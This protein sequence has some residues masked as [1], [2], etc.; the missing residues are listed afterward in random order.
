MNTARQE[1]DIC[2]WWHAY[3]FDNPLRRLLH[4]PRRLFA[5]YLS[6]GMTAV[7][8]GCGMGYFSIGMSKIVGDGGKILAVDVQP[9]M[10]SVLRRRASRAGVNHIIDTCLIAGTGLD[11][12]IAVDFALVFWAMHEIPD[13]NGLAHEITNGLKP[14]G[15]C[16]VVEPAF[17]VRAGAFA[18]QV[19]AFTTSGLRE[20]A[21]PKVALSRA[22]VFKKA[23]SRGQGAEG[24][25]GLPHQTF[26]P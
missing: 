17:H 8:I 16:F 19:S 5:D 26:E 23:G 21:R 11:L 14:G 2:T 22:A 6:A 9:Q 10:L 3:F 24:T 4:S 15:V 7:D 13:S 20:I 12:N 25:R 18:A 1:H